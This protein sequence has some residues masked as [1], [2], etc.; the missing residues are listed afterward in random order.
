[1]AHI[2]LTDLVQKVYKE[3]PD[4]LISTHRVQPPDINKIFEKLDQEIENQNKVVYL[5]KIKRKGSSKKLGIFKKAAVL[6]AGIIILSILIPAIMDTP[7][8]K[9]LKF[10]IVNTMIRIK[11]Q[12]IEITNSGDSTE[13]EASN[14]T[15]DSIEEITTV[16]T[17]L[18]EAKTRIDAT[19]LLSTELPSGYELERIEW[20]KY[21]DQRQSITQTYKN[22]QDIL[23]ITQLVDPIRNQDKTFI[24]NIDESSA[25]EIVVAD[26]DILLVNVGNEVKRAI[27]YEDDSRCEI[28]GNLTEED[29]VNIIKSIEKS[30]D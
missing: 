19:L 24:Q 23:E 13:D 2:K 5:Y 12:I 15:N 27:W 9:A 10:N 3:Y 21:P 4:K 16:F 17:N 7:Q 20:V 14:Q 28:I 6:T 29:I 1:M 25:K 26:R 8:A 30:P 11:D 18:D 22:K